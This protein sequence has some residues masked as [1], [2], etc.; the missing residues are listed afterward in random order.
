[1]AML[2]SARTALRE[3]SNRSEIRQFEHPDPRRGFVPGQKLKSVGV[4]TNHVAPEM[5]VS[6]MKEIP[7]QVCHI[8]ILCFHVLLTFVTFSM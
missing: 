1:M 5:L 3:D 7:V 4:P 6:G 2:E 8:S